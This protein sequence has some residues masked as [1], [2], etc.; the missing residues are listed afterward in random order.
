MAFGKKY[1]EYKDFFSVLS[2]SAHVSENIHY[3]I[4]EDVR[5]IE[6]FM[7]IFLKI[8]ICFLLSQPFDSLDLNPMPPSL[9]T[10]LTVL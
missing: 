4:V 6:M 1:Q 8:M 10:A 3:T 2:Y 5:N 7:S 9:G